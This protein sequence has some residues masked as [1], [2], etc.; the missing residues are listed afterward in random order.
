VK[1]R[2]GVSNLVGI[3]KYAPDEIC[4]VCEHKASKRITEA[5]VSGMTQWQVAHKFP[6]LTFRDIDRHMVECVQPT[7]EKEDG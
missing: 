3:I 4:A 1:R 5:L 7:I 2:R 6:D